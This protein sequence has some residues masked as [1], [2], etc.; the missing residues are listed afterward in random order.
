MVVYK[1]CANGND[2]LLFHTFI[3]GDYAPL[4]RTLCHR[5]S[6]IGADGLVVVLPIRQAESRLECSY[7]WDFYNADGSRAEMCGNASRCVAYYAYSMG[8]APAAHQ[9]LST[10]GV[11]KVSV[12]HHT[13]VPISDTNISAKTALVASNL[14][15]YK[16]LKILGTLETLLATLQSDL[17]STLDSIRALF[18]EWYF[19]DTGVPHLVCFVQDS[20][21]VAAL[22]NKAAPLHKTLF[23]L[24]Q[25]L[26][27]HYNA[28]VNLAYIQDQATIAL[29]T[30]ERGVE[31]I[32]LACGT[33]MAACFV[34]GYKAYH[35]AQKAT[36]IPPS[37][38]QVELWCE[39]TRDFI[40]AESNKVSC[41]EDSCSNVLDPAAT[42]STTIKSSIENRDGTEEICLQGMVRC[43][44]MC[45][46]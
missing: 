27:K 15:R 17:L 3:E 22:G 13:V 20:T 9:F 39:P 33:G 44:A 24:M 37:L 21:L 5:F 36:L 14:G 1:Y 2:F 32:T 31:D 43:V 4:A 45:E 18:G 8:L 25:H 26:R 6:G 29:A 46:V 23:L 19:L 16:N 35:T 41:I 7:M 30:Y 38:E 28:N 34:V 42:E 11:I 40:Q 12:K 10:F